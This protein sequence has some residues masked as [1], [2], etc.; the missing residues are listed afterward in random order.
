MSLQ[1][2]FKKETMLKM[3]KFGVTGGLG[4]ISNLALFFIFADKL[5]FPD[6]LT[7]VGCFI[8]TGTQNYFINHA[9][10]FRKQCADKPSIEHWF[11]FMSSS[12]LGLA[13]NIGSYILLSR[14]LEW[15]Y[16]VVPQAIGIL[17]GM[18]VNFTIANSFV[19]KGAR[20]S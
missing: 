14:L 1:H 9:W 2:V 16:K 10:T 11:Q 17:A 8:I 13:I 19:F 6:I 20:Q 18:A 3:I 7:S 15:P 12:L 5:A 4:T